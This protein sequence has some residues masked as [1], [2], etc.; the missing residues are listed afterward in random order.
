MYKVNGGFAH[1]GYFVF[2]VDPLPSGY[3]D[4]TVYLGFDYARG[5]SLPTQVYWRLFRFLFPESIHD[6]LWN[7]ALC[8]FRQRAENLADVTFQAQEKP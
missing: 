5:H 2:E 3:S 7:H 4:V 6:V 1:G 8:E